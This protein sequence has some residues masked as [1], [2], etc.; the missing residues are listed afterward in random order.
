VAVTSVLKPCFNLEFAALGF[1]TPERPISPK[2][3]APVIRKQLREF[4]DGI[5]RP[6]FRGL[7]KMACYEDYIEALGS[8]QDPEA[9]ELA[10]FLSGRIDA[11]VNM[12]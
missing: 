10:Q 4:R 1:T 6:P 7:V 5:L 8:I 3:T 9:Q 2:K 12:T 11:V